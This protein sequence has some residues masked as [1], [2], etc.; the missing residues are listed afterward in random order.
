MAFLVPALGKFLSSTQGTPLS[1][2]PPDKPTPGSLFPV[3]LEGL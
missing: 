2:L 3:S 1:P